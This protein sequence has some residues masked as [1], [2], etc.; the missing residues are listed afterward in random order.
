MEKTKISRSLVRRLT[1][2]LGLA[3]ALLGS[4]GWGVYHYTTSSTVE[5]GMSPDKFAH[6]ASSVKE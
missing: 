5:T 1:A 6:S 3:V 2:P 4:G